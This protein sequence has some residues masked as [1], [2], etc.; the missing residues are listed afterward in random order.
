MIPLAPD[1]AR[2]VLDQIASG[3][4]R[5]PCQF[6]VQVTWPPTVTH[7]DRLYSRSGKK[8]LRRSD[9]TPTAEYRAD[10]GRRLWLGLDGTVAED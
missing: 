1:V 2:L 5:Y 7:N 8:G 3:T 4:T 9:G 10:R 6:H